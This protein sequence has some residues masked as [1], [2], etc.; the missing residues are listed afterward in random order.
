MARRK[1][2]S[3]RTRRQRRPLWLRLIVNGVRLAVA[4]AFLFVVFLAYVFFTLDDK[5]PFQI[6]GHAPG[7]LIIAEDGTKLA[8][9]GSFF[10]DEARLE[11]LPK[12]LLNAVV[13]IEDRRFWHHPG[14][15]PISLVRAMYVNWRAGRVVQGGSTLTQQLAKNLFL[16]HKRT[17]WRKAQEAALA[18]WLEWKLSKKEILSLYLNRVYLGAGAYGVEKAARRYFGKPAAKLTLG[19]SAIIAGLLKA[20]SVYNPLRNRQ[21]A[22]QRARVVLAAMREAGYIT[23][24]QE[25]TALNSVRLKPT[26]LKGDT[27]TGYVA[28]HIIAQLPRL[29]GEVKESVLVQTT[30]DARLQRQ[31]VRVL[32]RTLAR[33][34]RKRRIGQGAIVALAPDGA[35]R[36]MIGGRAYTKN[37]FNRA[38]QA[39]RQPGSAFKP[40]VY[41]AALENGFTPV[42][43]LNDAPVR[44]GDYAPRNH[45]GKYYGPVTLTTALAWS[46]NSVAVQLAV[47]VGPA[48]V[49]Q[50]ANRLGISSAL[51][52]V[53]AIA[54]GTS[55]VSPLELTAAYAPFANGGKLVA[56]YVVTRVIS[57]SGKILYERR[58]SGLGRVVNPKHIGMMN[59]MLRAVIRSGTARNAAFKGQD[60]AGKTGTSQKYRDAWF[61]GFSPYLITAVWLGNDDNTPMRR[62]TGGSFP[63]VIWRQ[64]MAAAHKG[65]PFRQLPG[66]YLPP[67]P[68]REPVVARRPVAPPPPRREV[69]REAPR[70]VWDL[71]KSLFD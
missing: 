5:D 63:A 54:L 23:A 67:P 45:G 13:A 69:R 27:V 14:I 22:F 59:Y 36:V 29:I 68:P 52:P 49:A 28:D 24:R 39:K 3:A 18:L 57:R 9:R 16:E 20:P 55:P 46:L 11:K 38:V 51:D 25:K 32:Q 64:V 35:L 62:V 7:V 61:V 48:T 47:R 66:Y 15:D 56:P 2:T 33:N 53:P 4:G 70:T 10:G 41:L 60:I 44:Y 37:A 50:T 1:S 31:A 43:V 42:S 34:G 71:V 19:E 17:L 12:H 26:P 8:E 40:F 6:P 21:R 58:G 65:K 30:I